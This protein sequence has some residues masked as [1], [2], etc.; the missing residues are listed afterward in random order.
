MTQ[1][2]SQDMYMQPYDVWIINLDKDTGRM[3]HMVE[4]CRRYGFS[5]QR[6]SAVSYDRLPPDL[7]DF[8][9]DGEGRSFSNLKKGEIG[10]FASHILLLKKAAQ[11]DKPI[12]ILEDDLKFTSHVLELNAVLSEAPCDWDI[13]RLSNIS[14]NYALPIACLQARPDIKFLEYFRIPNNTGASLVSPRGARKFLD[15]IRNGLL[16]IDEVLR[17]PWVH[18]CITYGMSPPFFQSNIFES[19]I[20]ACEQRPDIGARKQFK[21]KYDQ[22]TISKKLQWQCYRWGILKTTKFYTYDIFQKIMKK[23][24][25]KKNNS[26]SLS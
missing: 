25:I 15:N 24:N 6:F 17:R 4:E 21:I 22:D 19:A 11:N 16:P 3:K 5:Y 1:N 18:G 7:K 13:I 23:F 26:D 9:L 10:C 8:F 20:D 12:L 2:P 14:K